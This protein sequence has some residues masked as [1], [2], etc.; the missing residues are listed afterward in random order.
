LVLNQTKVFPARIFGTKESGGKV[1]VVFLSESKPRIW[2][3]IIG[4]KVTDGQTIT[5]SDGFLGV[6]RKKEG[7]TFIEVAQDKF[8]LFS[9]LEK[10]GQMPLPPYMKRGATKEDKQDYQTV[11]AKQTGS[12]AA[13]TAGLHFT[14]KLLQ[15]LQELGVQIEYVT[16]HVG[17]GTFAPVK[18]EVLEDH[19]I[20]SEYYEIE[21]DVAERL[22]LA[23]K[24]GRRIVACGT[25][26]VRTLESAAQTGKIVAAKKETKL[27]IYPGYEFR[28]VDAIITNFHTPKSSLLGLVFAFAGDSNVKAAYQHAIDEKYRFFSYGDGMLVI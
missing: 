19:P 11:F 12:A 21:P 23:K 16:L 27:F 14:D 22:N 5:F 13:P 10:L 17:L 25:T 18:T 1:E 20:H 3:V 2:E 9:I 4:G 15:K 6:V 28:A 8:E 24:E 26:V 7:A